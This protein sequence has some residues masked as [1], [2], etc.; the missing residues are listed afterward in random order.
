MTTQNIIV[1]LKMEGGNR[2]DHT[3]ISKALREALANR[4]INPDYYWRLAI[5]INLKKEENSYFDYNGKWP[6]SVFFKSY[7]KY[8]CVFYGNGIFKCYAKYL[9]DKTEEYELVYTATVN[10]IDF[11]K[12]LYIGYL[13]YD[14]SEIADII[15]D[16]S[17]ENVA[18][19]RCEKI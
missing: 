3:N 7:M 1:P 13:F 16:G 18:L 17:S 6:G 11:S 12:K 4:L 8:K 5:S 9:L 19:S 14:S 15:I 10:G 2:I